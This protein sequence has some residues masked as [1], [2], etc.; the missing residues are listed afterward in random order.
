MKLFGATVLT[1]LIL[2][3]PSV[4]EAQNASPAALTGTRLELT[5]RGEVKRIPDVAVIS[6][7]V[8]TQAADAA[9]AMRDNSG[10]MARVLAALKRAGVA[11]KDVTT[12]AINLTPQYRYNNNQP[13]VITGYQANNQVTVRFRDVTRSGV[14]LDALV[15]EGANEINGPTLT[16]DNPE[17]A[18]DEARVAAVKQARARAEIYASATGMKVKRIVS[19][20]ESEGSSPGPVPMMMMKASRE[21]ADTAIMPGEQNVGLNVSVVFELQ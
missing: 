9:S 1:A 21:A 12:S 19:I 17:A 6:T 11:D 16:I 2:A 4:A 3:L 14:I 20:S 18:L 13:P 10:R 15:K 7:G 8:V 5:A